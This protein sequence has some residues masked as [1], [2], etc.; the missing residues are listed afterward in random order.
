MSEP[1]PMDKMNEDE[2][3]VHA[4]QLEGAVKDLLYIIQRVGDETGNAS[5]RAEIYEAR[6]LTGLPV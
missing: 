5:S 2:I 3:R 1:D 6:Q 4:K